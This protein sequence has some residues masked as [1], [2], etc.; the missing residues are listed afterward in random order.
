MI[1]WMF[2]RSC[3]AWT[4]AIMGVDGG[5]HDVFGGHEGQFGVDGAF[6]DVGVDDEAFD[7]VGEYDEDG[8]DGEEGLGD[9]EAFV[10][11]VVEGAFEPLGGGGLS[12][13]I[14]EGDDKA[15]EGGGAFAAHGVSLVGHCGGADLFLFEGFFQLFEV[16]E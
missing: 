8:V 6:E 1:S 15:G 9:G 12:G 7:D 3:P 14:G 2:C 5:H 16:G 4:A 10:G 13:G 11:G